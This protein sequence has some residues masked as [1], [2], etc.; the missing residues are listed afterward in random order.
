MDLIPST[1]CIYVPA[2]YFQVYWKSVTET[3]AHLVVLNT[4]RND[5]FVPVLDRILDRKGK[6]LIVTDDDQFSRK[7]VGK[8]FNVDK[9]YCYVV[10]F[11]VACLDSCWL[12]VDVSLCVC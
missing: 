2:E 8:L 11:H 1:T 5:L 4:T 3:T 6:G 10:G 7:F 12:V 9:S